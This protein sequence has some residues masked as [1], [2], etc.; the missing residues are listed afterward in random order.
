[1]DKSAVIRLG[2]DLAQGKVQN[3]SDG[4]PDDVMRK[5]MDS[6]VTYTKD[7][8]IDYKAMRRNKVEIY[9]IL[10]EVVSEVVNEGLANQFE[11]FVEYRNVAWGDKPEFEVP[12]NELYRVAEVVNGV[13][14]IR[15]QQLRENETFSVELNTYAVKIFEE[16]HRFLAGRVDWVKMMA[17]I[18]KSFEVQIKNKIFEVLM[19]TYGKQYGAPYHV[20]GNPDEHLLVEM[21]SHIKARTGDDVAMYGTASALR[22]FYPQYEMGEGM[23]EYNR[24]G[25][26]SRIAGVD[27]YEIPNSHKIGTDEFVIGDDFV[28]LLPQSPDRLIKV[29]NEGSAIIQETN[30]GV[31]ADMVQEHL[32]TNR[33]GIAVVSSKAYGFYRFM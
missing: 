8:K 9:E 32:V 14:D 10:E 11:K 2:I 3:Y 21:V 6:L 4:N 13:G 7:G 19:A 33:F 23:T 16:F 18:G 1:M 29:V 25:Y 26:R 12:N 28:L 22:K 31:T 24:D 30:A 20:T 27:T 5:A 15:R 17:N